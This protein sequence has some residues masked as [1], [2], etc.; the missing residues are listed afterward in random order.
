MTDR[1]K[2]LEKINGQL[3]K[4]KAEINLLEAKV[5]VAEAEAKSDYIKELEKLKSSSKQLE[6][7]IEEIKD[8]SGDAWQELTAGVDK[9][10][11]DLSEGL[12]SAIE[13]F[14]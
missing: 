7:R 8:A 3:T 9:A 2:Y 1:D 14:K 10:W 5:R 4:W 11:Q 12:D 13:R 6:A